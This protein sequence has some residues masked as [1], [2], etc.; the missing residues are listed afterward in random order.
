MENFIYSWKIDEKLCDDL[1][2]FYNKNKKE[3]GITGHTYHNNQITVKKDIKDSFDVFFYNQSQNETIIEYFNQLSMGLTNYM[4]KYDLRGYEVRT[5]PI[6]NIQYYPPGGGYKLWHSERGNK[7]RNRVLVYMTYLNTVENGGTEWY[8]QNYK[9]E[10]I[11]GLSVI[12]PAEFTH[13]HRG[14]ISKQE[15]YIATGWFELV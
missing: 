2:H 9:T 3:L 10:A 6:N 4:Q 12:W 5:E 13:L 11:K 7:L 1:I 8:Y 15:K 14:I